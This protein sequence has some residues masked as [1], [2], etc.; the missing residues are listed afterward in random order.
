MED[1]NRAEEFWQ[2]IDDVIV[3]E[4]CRDRAIENYIIVDVTQSEES[5]CPFEEWDPRSF[6]NEKYSCSMSW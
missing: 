3:A 5:R 6:D 1:I 2:K 4:L